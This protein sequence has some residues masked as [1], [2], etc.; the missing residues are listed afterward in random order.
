MWKVPLWISSHKQLFRS[1]TNQHRVLS[2][3]YVQMKTTEDLTLFAQAYDGHVFRG[4]DGE[5]RTA[6]PSPTRSLRLTVFF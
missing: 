2:R 3:A 1:S 5:F 6:S 4:K